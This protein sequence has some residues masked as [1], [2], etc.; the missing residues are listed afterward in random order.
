[1]HSAQRALVVLAVLCLLNTR[2]EAAII[3]FDDIDASAGDVSLDALSP[4][5]GFSWSNFFA[6]TSPRDSKGPS[7]KRQTARRF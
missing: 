4:Y 1:M 7:G 2:L 3:G 6:Y 5:Q